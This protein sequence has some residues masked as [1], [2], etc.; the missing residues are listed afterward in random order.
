MQAFDQYWVLPDE[1]GAVDNPRFE[2]SAE[3]RRSSV[4]VRASR[5]GAPSTAT[6]GPGRD[7]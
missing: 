7:E 2:G 4:P 1:R 5:A 3:E 6:L